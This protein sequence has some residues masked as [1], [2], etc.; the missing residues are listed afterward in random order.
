MAEAIINQDYNDNWIAYSA[1]TNP[2][3]PNPWAVQV[4]AEISI[5]ISQQH[6]KS[7][8]E[9]LNRDDIDLVITVCDDARETC[10]IFPVNTKLIHINIED[11]APFTDQPTEIALCMFRKTREQIREK[12]N[13]II[14]NPDSKEP[15][16]G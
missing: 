2:S 3:E 13:L 12:L 6:S 15:S 8:D 4:M 5:D 14:E 9:F 16:E 1:G 11:P 10:P 7:V